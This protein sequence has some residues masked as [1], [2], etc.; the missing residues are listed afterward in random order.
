[1]ENMENQEGQE[2]RQKEKAL[3]PD[4]ELL[5]TFLD[6]MTKTFENDSSRTKENTERL[7]ESTKENNE[8]LHESFDRTESDRRQLAASLFSFALTLCPPQESYGG[9]E[10]YGERTEADLRLKVIEEFLTTAFPLTFPFGRSLERSL[11][12]GI[13]EDEGE[14]A[15]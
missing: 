13:F 4:I 12:F 10:S 15:G 8:R 1:M 6:K 3:P 9:Q 14:Q 2:D 7:H 11:G 5:S